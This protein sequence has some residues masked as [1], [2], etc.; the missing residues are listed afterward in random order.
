MMF[1]EIL[2]SG[3]MGSP[4]QLSLVGILTFLTLLRWH[5][6]CLALFTIVEIC[7]DHDKSS[8]M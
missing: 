6:F 2:Y 3:S 8:E 5:R 4:L 1:L 7:G